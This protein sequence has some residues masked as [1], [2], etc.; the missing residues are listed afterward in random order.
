MLKLI[1]GSQCPCA[2][3]VLADALAHAKLVHEVV[4]CDGNF[5]PQIWE[6]GSQLAEGIEP[7]AKFIEERRQK[8]VIAKLRS[9]QAPQS[10]QVAAV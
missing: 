1:E 4:S 3:E 7:C 5:S 6:N 2:N 8:R 10:L 9:D